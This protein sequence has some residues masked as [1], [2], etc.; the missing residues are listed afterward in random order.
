MKASLICSMEAARSLTKHLVKGSNRVILTHCQYLVRNLLQYHRIIEQSV[1]EGTSQM[2]LDQP[3]A[4]N[5]SSYMGLLRTTSNQ[6]LMISKVGLCL[7]NS[8][9]QCLSNTT[10]NLF[11]SNKKFPCH[12]LHYLLLSYHCMAPRKVS[13][14]YSPDQPLITANSNKTP[15]TSFLKAE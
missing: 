10:L 12:D 8:L 15:L 9:F 5:K 1:L 6:A 4:Q 14:L 3:L 13:L 11:L 2:S 7:S